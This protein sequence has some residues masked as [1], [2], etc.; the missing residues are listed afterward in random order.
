[1]KRRAIFLLGVFLIGLVPGYSVP[2][3]EGGRELEDAL[4]LLY[5]SRAILLDQSDLGDAGVAPYLMAGAPFQTGGEPDAGAALGNLIHATKQQRN[6][7]NDACRE[8]K[9]AY[10]GGAKRCERQVLS[11]HCDAQRAKLNRRIGFLHKL[12]GDRRKLFTRLWHSV[13]RAGARVWSAVGPIGRRILRKVGPEVAQ[14]VLSGGSLSG[15]VLRKILIRHARDVGER[16]LERLVSRG[17]ERFLFGQASL[18]RA[19]GVADCSEKELSAAKDRLKSDLEGGQE[20]SGEAGAEDNTQSGESEMDES[21]FGGDGESCD[22]GEPW[23]E[24]AWEEV[25]VPTMKEKGKHCFDTSAYYD[26]LK[27]Q[28]ADGACPMTAFGVCEKVYQE[29]LPSRRGQKVTIVDDTAFKWDMDNHIDLTFSLDGGP[30]SG[31]MAYYYER[32][33]ASDDKDICYVQGTYSFKGRYNPRTC[34]LSGTGTESFAWEG[35]T[36]ISCIGFSEPYEGLQKPWK[37]EIKNGRLHTC[38]EQPHSILCE[39]YE[40]SD[41]VK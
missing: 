6:N 30:V 7:L 16:E 9:A 18:A 10:Q 22:P 29:I 11:D 17:L 40:L 28:Q 36:E 33:F 32:G 37:M 41:Y 19:A 4:A 15:G 21:L 35:S 25:L 31:Y 39:V 8:L 13:K 20:E 23:L 14:I 5:A 38:S 2:A 27:Q 24:E 1:M 3:Q 12:R 26:C 34:T